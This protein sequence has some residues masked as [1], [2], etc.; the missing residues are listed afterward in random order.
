MP[1]QPEVGATRTGGA[2]DHEAEPVAAARNTEDA[3]FC[4][5]LMSYGSLRAPTPFLSTSPASHVF[6][7]LRPDQNLRVKPLVPRCFFI[8]GLITSKKSAFAS[9][10]TRTNLLVES[11]KSTR[12]KAVCRAESGGNCNL[13]FGNIHVG[14][15][16]RRNGTLDRSPRTVCDICLKRV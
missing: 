16:M 6:R 13:I 11:T 1:D 14:Q 5:S 8:R 7:S 4:S 9:T 12:R 3:F 10:R 15:E 2:I